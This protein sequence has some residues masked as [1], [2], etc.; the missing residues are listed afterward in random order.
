MQACPATHS[1]LLRQGGSLMCFVPL[2]LPVPSTQPELQARASWEM[3]LA[4]LALSKAI[5]RSVYKWGL[6]KQ[7]RM[8]R[9]KP[10]TDQQP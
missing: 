10:N 9:L 1:L 6:W 7:L 3:R 8:T 5:P 2:L 4:E